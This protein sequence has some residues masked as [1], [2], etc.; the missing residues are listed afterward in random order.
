MDPSNLLNVVSAVTRGLALP[1]TQLRE[2]W[3]KN[4]ICDVDNFHLLVSAWPGALQVHMCH[5]VAVRFA[6]GPCQWGMT[7]PPAWGWVPVP[8]C[9][10]ICAV[11][12]PHPRQP[13]PTGIC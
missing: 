1:W 4:P 13:N 11:A 5:Y 6:A 9:Y 12:P 8:C 10:V 2:Y 7:E 3:A